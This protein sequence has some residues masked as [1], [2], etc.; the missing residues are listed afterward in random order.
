[1]ASTHYWRRGMAGNSWQ[2]AAGRASEEKSLNF[3]KNLPE[4]LPGF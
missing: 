3:Q 1:M 2:G 4:E